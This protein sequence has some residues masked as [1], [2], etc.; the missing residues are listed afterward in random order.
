MDSGTF[1]MVGC[2]A[3]TMEHGTS[4]GRAAGGD[5]AALVAALVAN[6]PH[7][8]REFLRRYE[9]LLWRSIANTTARFSSVC[10]CDLRDIYAE[11]LASLLANDR[12]KLRAFDP[13]RGSRFST[14]LAMLAI[15]CAYDHLRSL[16]RQPRRE[17]LS[18][19]AGLPDAEA[20]PYESAV[21]RERASLAARVLA[22][23]SERDRV[24]ATLYFGE[25]LEPTEI[26]RSMNITLKTVYS[27]KHK[28]KAKLESLVARVRAERVAS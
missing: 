23:F 27:K 28:I 19:L 25:G 9:A 21:R 11:L 18:E 6:D 3:F 24:F 4:T 1:E 20:D 14:Y 2:E 7:A 13:A 22:G 26:A 17:Q 12:A 5:E 15:H 10:P 8:W 16:R